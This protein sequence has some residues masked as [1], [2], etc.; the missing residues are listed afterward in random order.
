MLKEAAS[1]AVDG[2]SSTGGVR[3][4]RVAAVS[5]SQ[6]NDVLVAELSEL[7]DRVRTLTAERDH[8]RQRYEA[9]TLAH[10]SDCSD[11][12]NTNPVD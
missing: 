3:L 5:S 8:F 1:S 6:L 11:V 4:P 10:T 7:R 2:E 9:V 12:I